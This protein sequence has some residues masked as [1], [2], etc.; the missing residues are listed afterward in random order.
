MDKNA[1]VKMFSASGSSNKWSHLMKVL[2]K[3]VVKLNK[4]DQKLF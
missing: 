4:L 3:R 1:Y 2:Y